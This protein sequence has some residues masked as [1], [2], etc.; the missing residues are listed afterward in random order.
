MTPDQVVLKAPGRKTFGLELQLQSGNVV[1][2]GRFT[3][4]GDFN[5]DPVS[6]FSLSTAAGSTSAFLLKITLPL[7][8]QEGHSLAGSEYF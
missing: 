8:L 4:T 7:L 5:P 2:G 3:G 6:T 1:L